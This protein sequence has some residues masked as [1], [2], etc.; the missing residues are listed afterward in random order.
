MK[1]NLIVLDVASYLGAFVLCLYAFT[2]VGDFIAYLLKKFPP[3]AAHPERAHASAPRK[4]R[5]PT[6]VS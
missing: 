6:G 1:E 4:R 3:D 2:R 5:R